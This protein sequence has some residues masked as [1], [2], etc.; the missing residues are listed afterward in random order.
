MRILFIGDAPTVSTGFS[1]CTR[2]VCNRLHAN[3]HEVNVLGI[4]YYGGPHDYPYAIY[5]CVDP[6]DRSLMVCGEQRLPKLI[7]RLNP[8]VVIVLQDPWNINGYFR[9][10]WKYSGDDKP[11]A[12][13]IGWLAVDSKNQCSGRELNTLDHVVTWTQFGIN[14]L[15]SGGY[16][17]PHSIIGLGVDT[18]VYCPMDRLEAR[19]QILGTYLSEPNI[20]PDAYIVGVVGRNQVR[21]RLDLNLQYLAEWIKRYEITDAYLCLH[22]GPTG[23]S[24]VDIEKLCNYYGLKVITLNPPLGAGVPESDMRAIYNMFDL[25]WS[26]SQAEGWNLPALEAMACGVP[27]LLPE[28]GAPAEW[29]ID[30]AYLV[31]CSSTALTA[32]LNAGPYT[33]G[34]IADRNET[35]LALDKLY[36]HADYRRKLSGLGLQLASRLSWDVVGEQWEALLQSLMSAKLSPT[37]TDLMVMPES[38]DGLP[39]SFLSR[40]QVKELGD[41]IDSEQREHG[42]EGVGLGVE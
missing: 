29:A 37:M 4:S 17:G 2:E 21:K 13:I 3:G 15:Q 24:G 42:P 6:L 40:E 25:Y 27:C 22:V 20:P 16:T 28:Q 12:T 1:K 38:I 8:D 39:D 36:R 7:Q 31:P 5:P 32:P 9:E 19:R 34:G 11:T 33:I 23:E 35:V 18:A 14:E 41:W 10:I 26:M 30:A